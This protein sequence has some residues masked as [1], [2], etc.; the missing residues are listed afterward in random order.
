MSIMTPP[1]NWMNKSKTCYK[2]GYSWI[3]TNEDVVTTDEE[4]IKF[5]IKCPECGT[6]LQPPST[7]HIPKQKQEEQ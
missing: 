1:V 2:C 7:Q 6:T 3:P 4:D 5:I